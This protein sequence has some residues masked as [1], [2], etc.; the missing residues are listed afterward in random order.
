MLPITEGC[1]VNEGMSGRRITEKQGVKTLGSS[2]NFLIRN[3]GGKKLLKKQNIIYIFF[4]QT[5]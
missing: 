1:G 2:E 4:V 5:K 3:L